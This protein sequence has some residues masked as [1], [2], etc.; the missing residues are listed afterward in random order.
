MKKRTI[1]RSIVVAALAAGILTGLTLWAKVSFR[2][3]LYSNIAGAPPINIKIDIDEY[4]PAEEIQKLSEALSRGD[5]DGFYRL[6]RSMNKGSIQFIGTLGVNIK[7]N[8]IQEQ[9]SEKGIKIFL[10]TES[11][12]IEPGT[13]RMKNVPWRFLVAV[14]ELDKNFNGEAMIYEDA[15]VDFL[16]QGIIEMKSSYSAPKSVVNVR[17]IK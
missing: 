17:L 15:V 14:L 1:Q 9:S 5:E 16:P 7:L 13:T 4:S 6:L 2:G 3:R 11:R 12:S 8:V 10:L